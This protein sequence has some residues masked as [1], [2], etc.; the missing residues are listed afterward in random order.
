MNNLATKIQQKQEQ[1]QQVK[2]KKITIKKKRD[3]TIGEKFLIVAFLGVVLIASVQIINNSLILYK[4]NQ[5]LQQIEADISKQEKANEEL[6]VYIDELKNP[7]LILKKAEELGLDITS[8][9]DK[10]TKNE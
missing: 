2:T 4:E 7:Q 9:N 8:I 5:L 10:G 1:S 3:I 6:I